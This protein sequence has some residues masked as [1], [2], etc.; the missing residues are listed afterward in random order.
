MDLVTK[1]TTPTESEG[2][3]LGTIIIT[4]YIPNI[5]DFIVGVQLL[6]L[7]T[8]LLIML[9]LRIDHGGIMITYLV[10][11]LDC[12]GPFLFQLSPACY[13]HYCRCHGL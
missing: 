9:M 5:L 3:V 7:R 6:C 10:I 2:M 11:S 8:W 12:Y 4:F 1:P 13:V